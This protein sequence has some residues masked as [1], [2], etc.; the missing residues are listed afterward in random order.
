[1]NKVIRPGGLTVFAVGNFAF[2]GM[3]AIGV[4]LSFMSLGCSM[5]IQGIEQNVS[6]PY[7]AVSI[8]LQAAA[9]VFLLISAA[10]TLKI[11]NGSGRWFA[12]VY[13]VLAIIRIISKFI[14]GPK[15]ADNFSMF[16]IISLIYPVLVL[17][18]Y[19]LVFRDIWNIE[20]Y[21]VDSSV[22]PPAK[23][24]IGPVPHIPLIAGQSIKQTLRSPAGVIMFLVIMFIGL[25]TAQLLLLPI[26]FVGNQAGQMGMEMDRENAVE[27]IES[28]AV[29]L[30]GRILKRVT[31]EPV[32]KGGGLGALLQPRPEQRGMELKEEGNI[33]D[34]EAWAFFLIRKKPAFLSVLF[35]LFCMIIPSIVIFSSFNQIAGD[36]KNRGLRYILMRTDRQSLFIGKL[37]G[38]IAVTFLFL[39]V[40]FISILLYVRIKL[41]LYAV[42]AL[43]QWGARGLIGFT[44]ISIP[45]IAL[46]LAFSALI[47]S[48]AG[49]LG[50]SLG[51]LIIVPLLGRLFHSIWGPLQFINVL[52]PY[53]LSFFIFHPKGWVVLVSVLGLFGY[54]ILYGAFGLLYFRRRD[55]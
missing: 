11:K 21:K 47:N 35:L 39:L 26:E 37:L 14:W 32:E 49:A 42:Y 30:L 53:K 10:G 12:N 27:Q 22:P 54:S 3:Q 28:T 8:L 15:G 50:A 29:P 17:F 45:Y 6:L 23:E 24:E 52:L 13:A 43:L 33:L 9:A 19:N 44:V 46:A 41:D 40:L 38:S 55:V 18:F 1:V 7:R 5:Q 31:G 16:S 2:G 34:A 48:G 36:A 51:M 20:A 4:L 25:F